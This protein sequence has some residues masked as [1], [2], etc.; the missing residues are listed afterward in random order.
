[1]L[2]FR[3]VRKAHIRLK[4]ID[5]RGKKEIKQSRFAFQKKNSKIN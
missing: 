4:K 3:K 5:V 2:E 1:M